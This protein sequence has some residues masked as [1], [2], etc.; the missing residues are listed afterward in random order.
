M[1]PP[2]EHG[3]EPRRG[4]PHNRVY[5]SRGTEQEVKRTDLQTFGNFVEYPKGLLAHDLRRGGLFRR[6]RSRGGRSEQ[7]ADAFRQLSSVA[8]PVV[9]PIAF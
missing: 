4:T 3:G 5:V 9:D 8:G 1:Q 6:D 7:L 2:A